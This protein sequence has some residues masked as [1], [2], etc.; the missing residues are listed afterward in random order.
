MWRDGVFIRP[1]VW[2]GAVFSNRNG[3][4]TASFLNYGATLL[5]F[6]APDR[7]GTVEVATG[8]LLHGIG[9]NIQSKDIG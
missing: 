1:E 5:S 8:I 3:T 9:D 2:I 7:N 6:T 4:L